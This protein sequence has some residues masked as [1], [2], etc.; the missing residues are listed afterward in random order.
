MADIIV[1]EKLEMN[2]KERFCINVQ[3]IVSNPDA[4]MYHFPAI[5]FFF[6]KH[7]GVLFFIYLKIKGIEAFQKFFF[8]QREEKWVSLF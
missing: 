2:F 6:T 7:K 8:F 1:E 3:G 4:I 5:I